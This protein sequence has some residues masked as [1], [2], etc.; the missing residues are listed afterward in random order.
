MIFDLD[1]TLVDSL[2]DLAAAMNATLDE[3]GY[4]SHPF[5]FYLPLIGGG[6]EV[7]IAGALPA[8]RRNP[9]QVAAART[10]MRAHYRRHA[11]R[12]TRPYPGVRWLLAELVRSRVP[13][14]VLSNKLHEETLMVVRGVFP[15]VPFHAVLG[16]Q[17]PRAA[18]PDPAGAIAVARMLR[19][20]PRQLLL[21]GDG[22]TDMLAARRCGALPVGAT[23]GYRSARAL[24]AAGAAR[25]LSH[26]RAV[27]AY[28]RTGNDVTD[29]PACGR[30]G[31]GSPA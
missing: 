30:A 3:L 11:L 18:K 2:P 28:L 19:L 7:M 9:R 6:I 8:T 23:W 14:A 21:V 5:E 29:V 12:T 31:T 4:P 17:P 20:A 24:L 1:G 25:L 16:L 22:E 10:L 26:P 27:A 13:L 15:D